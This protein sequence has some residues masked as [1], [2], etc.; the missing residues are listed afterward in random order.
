[1]SGH[2]ESTARQGRQ[3]AIAISAGGLLAIL[4]P[5]IVRA[6]G[7]APRVEILLYLVSLAAFIWALVVTAR[8]WQKTRDR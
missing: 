2:D 4:A 8:I 1:M 3:A 6:L 7:L 5:V